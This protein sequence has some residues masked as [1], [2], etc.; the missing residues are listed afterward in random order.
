MNR[1]TSYEKAC[2]RCTLCELASSSEDSSPLFT[3]GNKGSDTLVVIASDIVSSE[4]YEQVYNIFGKPEDVCY[5]NAKRCVGVG[6][7]AI[8]NC[9]IYT[10]ALAVNRKYI[11]T[12]PAGAYQFTSTYEVTDYK[13][14][15]TFK[16]GNATVMVIPEECWAN[17]SVIKR[18][19]DE[20]SRLLSTTSVRRS[21]D[22][23]HS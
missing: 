11:F 6:E 20:V 21:K 22:A 2:E 3:F 12:I 23:N 13:P 19:K 15:G 18:T 10:R 9:S 17:K 7:E 1:L 4:N 16:Y 14:Y 5:T 8:D